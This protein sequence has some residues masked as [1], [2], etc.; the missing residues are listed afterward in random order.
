MPLQHTNDRNRTAG[1]AARA[2][3][4]RSMLDGAAREQLRLAVARLDD[5]ERAR[6]PY[7]LAT[8][9]IAVGRSYKRLQAL[10]AAEETLR[11]ALRWAVAT[12]SID[13]QVDL[14]CE[15]AEAMCEQA[16]QH[17][18]EDHRAAHAARE[19]AR[20]VVYQATSLAEHVADERWGQRALLRVSDVLNRCGDHDDAAWLQSRAMGMLPGGAALD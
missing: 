13:M 8:A 3:H 5:A 14:L 11:L 6:Q 16:D 1:D 7:E 15:L 20:D 4:G 18:G 17:A 9:L 2:S 19:R 10:P 12:G